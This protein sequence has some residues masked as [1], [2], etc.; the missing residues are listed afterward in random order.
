MTYEKGQVVKYANPQCV[1]EI[2]QTFTVI[3]DRG[4]RLL[5]EAICNMPLKPQNCFAKSQY[6]AV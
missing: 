5:V 4:D 2:G 6:V 3:E 1:M